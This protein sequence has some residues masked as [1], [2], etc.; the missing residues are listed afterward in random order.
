MSV[1]DERT[2]IVAA[3]AYGILPAIPII[4]GLMGVISHETPGLMVILI[5]FAMLSYGA[6]SVLSIS[7]MPTRTRPSTASAR[8]ACCIPPA[9]CSRRWTRRW[10]QPWPAWS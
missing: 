6:I 1:L 2:M 10:A 4:L 9:R 8:R 3:I 7:V 5:G